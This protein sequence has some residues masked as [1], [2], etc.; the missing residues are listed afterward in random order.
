MDPTIVNL[1]IDEILFDD[2]GRKGAE[3][4]YEVL[5]EAGLQTFSKIDDSSIWVKTLWIISS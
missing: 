3:W 2:V 4:K 5:W 1:H